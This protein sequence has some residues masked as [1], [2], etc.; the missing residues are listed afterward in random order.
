MEQECGGQSRRVDEEV[1]CIGFGVWSPGGSSVGL[2]LPMMLVLLHPPA[3]EVLIRRTPCPPCW[4]RLLG[5]RAKCWHLVRNAAQHST[6][7]QRSAAQPRAGLL[8][9]VGPNWART[10][11]MENGR[12][13][14]DVRLL[15]T[16]LACGRWEP[17]FGSR[18]GLRP[19]SSSSRGGRAGF[20]G[21]A[22]VVLSP[23]TGW[24]GKTRCWRWSLIT[25]CCKGSLCCPGRSPRGG[26]QRAACVGCTRQDRGRE[27]LCEAS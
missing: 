1:L 25:D 3:W 19:E 16:R 21:C 26:Q 18:P 7:P 10:C 27:R 11:W 13:R 22:Q 15:Q 23:R 14:E 5:G 8:V 20:E 17:R 24:R 12:R 9:A 4:G 2:V 6:A